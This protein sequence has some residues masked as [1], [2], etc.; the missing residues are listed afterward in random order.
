MATALNLGSL[1]VDSSGRAFLSGTGSGIDFS[2]AVEKI[3]EAKRQPA[4]SLEAKVTALADAANAAGTVAASVA[5]FDDPVAPTV[6]N[7]DM[8]NHIARAA[9]RHVPGAWMRMASAAGHDAQVIAARLPC[10]MLFVPS[11]GGVSHDFAEDTSED[12]IVLGCQVAA[13]AAASILQNA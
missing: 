4:I 2:D 1:T 11:I 13:T 3:I 9:E 10:G 6:M 7:D 8:Q 5:P 12:D